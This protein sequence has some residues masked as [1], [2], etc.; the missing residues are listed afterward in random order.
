[1]SVVFVNSK[2]AIRSNR[3]SWKIR[4]MSVA[5]MLGSMVLSCE[6]DIREF[7]R[8]TPIRVMVHVKNPCYDFMNF[9]TYNVFD[10]VD[11]KKFVDLSRFDAQ[12]TANIPKS[13]TSKLCVRIPHHDNMHCKIHKMWLPM[14]RSPIIGI[15]GNEPSIKSLKKYNIVSEKE[16]SSPCAF[17]D[18]VDIAVAWKKNIAFDAL[19]CERFTNPIA[20]NIPT[21]GY[22]YSSYKY[23]NFS[24]PFI[25][26]DLECVSRKVE[27]IRRGL[28]NH[29]FHLLRNEVMSGVSADRIQ[30]LYRALFQRLS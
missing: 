28:L 19:P 2:R 8:K 12:I 17:F 15:V 3:G 24:K 6:D 23:Y 4:G 10:A 25:C 5:R 16:F 9:S 14:E 11:N 27:E 20:W 30:R 22:S 13:C 29:E 7:T 18:R 1:M 26:R 21:I